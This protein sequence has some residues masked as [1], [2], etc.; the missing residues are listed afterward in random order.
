M[1]NLFNDYD[2]QIMMTAIE[3]RVDWLFHSLWCNPKNDRAKLGKYRKEIIRL[4]EL[5]F[6]LRG[7]SNSISNVYGV[8]YEV[9]NVHSIYVLISDYKGCE[10]NE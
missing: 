3:R 10:E 7:G 5:Y 9:N 1:K 8:D 6:E 4:C 2:K